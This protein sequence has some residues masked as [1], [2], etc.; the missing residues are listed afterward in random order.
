MPASPDST[1]TP[2]GRAPGVGRSPMASARRDRSVSRPMR[3]P[4]LSGIRGIIAYSADRSG[5]VGDTCR[6]RSSPR[7]ARVVLLSGDPRHGAAHDLERRVAADATTL[8]V[9]GLDLDLD[10]AEVDVLGGHGLS[11][12]RAVLD[13]SRLG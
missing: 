10:G 11:S 8:G 6:T 9:A 2:P 5:S 7:A 3:G 12:A 13:S 1:T 4:V